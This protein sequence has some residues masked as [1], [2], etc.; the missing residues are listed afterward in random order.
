MCCR[1]GSTDPDRTESMKQHE[2]KMVLYMQRHRTWLADQ[3]ALRTNPDSWVDEYISDLTSTIETHLLDN[4]TF[5][6]KNASIKGS[7]TWEETVHR[8]RRLVGMFHQERELTKQG[9]EIPLLALESNMSIAGGNRYVP[10][11]YSCHDSPY[12]L[13]LTDGTCVRQSKQTRVQESVRLLIIVA[14]SPVKS[15]SAI[16]GFVF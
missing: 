13:S 9:L 10:L 2:K 15:S 12:C 14:C 11:I 6:E 4:R 8:A 1:D 3:Y 7:S 16:W 5:M